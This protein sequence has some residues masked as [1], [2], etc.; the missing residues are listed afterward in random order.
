M[1]DSHDTDDEG[2]GAAEAPLA[3]GDAARHVSHVT[4]MSADAA[5]AY[6]A[7]HSGLRAQGPAGPRAA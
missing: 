4:G 5:K 7:F 2:T 3:D 1:T 6:A